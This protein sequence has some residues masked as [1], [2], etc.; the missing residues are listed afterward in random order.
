MMLSHFPSIVNKEFTANLELLLDSVGEGQLNWKT[1]IENFYPDLD[2]AV[3]K[4]EKEMESVKIS[5]EESDVVCENCGRKMVIKY[6]PS[7]KFLACPGFPECRNTKPYYKKIGVCCPE[8]GRE[9][10]LKKTL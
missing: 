7:G 8:C 9:V 2:T 3:E 5:D 4:A 10:V 1:V 6:G